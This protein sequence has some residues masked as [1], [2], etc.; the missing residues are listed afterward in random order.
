MLTKGK[1]KFLSSQLAYFLD[2]NIILSDKLLKFSIC[3][4][5]HFNFA[6][7]LNAIL[8]IQ[9]FLKKL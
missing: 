5:K 2:N 3:F 8:L 1:N 9:R 6:R 4:V 7:I